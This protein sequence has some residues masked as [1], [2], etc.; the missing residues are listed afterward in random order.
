MRNVIANMG[1]QTASYVGTFG[2]GKRHKG[3]EMVTV[4]GRREFLPSKYFLKTNPK[5]NCGCQREK[6]IEREG[7]KI[8][9]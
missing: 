9:V 5:I 4:D 1:A 6:R 2:L 7:V 8:Q 3:G